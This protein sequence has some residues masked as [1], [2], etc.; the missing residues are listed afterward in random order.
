MKK[1]LLLLMF[2]FT[3]LTVSCGEDAKASSKKSSFNKSTSK[4]DYV[5]SLNV[6]NKTMTSNFN[7]YGSSS[8]NKTSVKTKKTTLKKNK[9]FN[10][11]FKGNN[12]NQ[13]N[14][15]AYTIN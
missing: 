6:N 13:A 8:L 2:I 15:S 14:M 3:A 11:K 4:E 10:K 12:M 5:N 7:S 9:K 1:L